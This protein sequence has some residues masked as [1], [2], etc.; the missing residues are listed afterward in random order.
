MKNC[1]FCAEEIQD[2]AVVC[3]HCGRD[4]VTAPREQPAKPP[5]KKTKLTT[6]VVAIVACGLLYSFCKTSV[7]NLATSTAQNDPAT[8]AKLTALFDKAKSVGMITKVESGTDHAYVDPA[9]WAALSIDDKKVLAR[10]IAQHFKA[11]GGVGYAHI[12]DG[13]SG[14]HIAVWRSSGT[15]EVD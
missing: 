4:L 3:K 13:R 7:D 12:Y 8:D 6:W 1:Q 11:R 2:A 10:A 15:F 5:K 14:K 9:G